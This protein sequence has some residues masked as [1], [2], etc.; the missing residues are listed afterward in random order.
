M[1]Y[2]KTRATPWVMGIGFLALVLS[3]HSSAFATDPV[4]SLDVRFKTQPDGSV[5]TTEVPDF[6]R[7]ANFYRGEGPLSVK[8]AIERFACLY[9][10]VKLEEG[11]VWICAR[12]DS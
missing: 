9:F 6:Q 11:L 4:A 1:K 5:D 2:L 12:E 3:T 7:T 8:L 10:L